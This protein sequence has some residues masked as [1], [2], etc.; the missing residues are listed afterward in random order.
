MILGE[1]CYKVCQLAT[2]DPCFANPP[3][4]LLSLYYEDLPLW[5]IPQLW[6][7]PSHIGKCT[8]LHFYGEED[9]FFKAKENYSKYEYFCFSLSPGLL[10]EEPS[11]QKGLDHMDLD[12][13]DR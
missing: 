11:L 12:G 5:H 7:Y 8:R 3:E 1:I 6:Y 2:T 13:K 9:L 10:L 4:N